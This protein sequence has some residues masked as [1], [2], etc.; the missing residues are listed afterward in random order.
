MTRRTIL[1]LTMLLA[2]L[3]TVGATSHTPIPACREDSGTVRFMSYNIR[4]GTSMSHQQNLDGQIAVMRSWNPDFIMLQE[5]DVRCVRSRSIHQPKRIA[6]ALGMH[7]TFAHTIRILWNKYGIALISRE[8]PLSVE[9]YPL[10]CKSEN[11]ML[12]VCEFEDKYVACTHLSTQRAENMQIVDIITAAARKAT[13]PFY[14]G[15]DWN[16]GPDSQLLDSLRKTFT[17]LSDENAHTFP[18]NT[19]KACI[20]YI[21]VYMPD[22]TK[23]PEVTFQHVA[24]EPQASDHRPVIIDVRTDENDQHEL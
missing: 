10:P 11:R 5:V 1:F 12:L 3:H 14:I 9:R 16:D 13:K 6:K 20:D 24:D 8:K 2:V 23:L 19:P 18:A 7:A 21:A 22:G 17:V 4:H 15:G